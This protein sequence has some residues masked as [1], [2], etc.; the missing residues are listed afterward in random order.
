MS[1]TGTDHITV[2]T[3]NSIRIVNEEGTVIYLD[4]LGIEGEPKDDLY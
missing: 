2:N 3:Q 4:P 1:L